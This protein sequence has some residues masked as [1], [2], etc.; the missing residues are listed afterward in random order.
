MPAGLPGDSAANNLANPSAGRPVIFDPLSG[1]KGSPFDKG[2][3]GTASTGA[4]STGI[5]FGM[6]SIFYALQRD[7][8]TLLSPQVTAA[9]AG[10]NYNQEP[11]TKP[12]YAAPPP[13]N[14]VTT[15][16]TDGRYM[17]IGGGR[18]TANATTP[19]KYSVPFVANPYV[20]GIALLAAG[21]GGSRD[22]GAGPAFTGFGMRLLA[23]TGAVANGNVVVVGYTTRSGIGLVNGQSVFTSEV[24]A[25]AAPA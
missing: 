19:D 2:S 18:S 7:G 21:N 20:T 24:A 3:V 23:A 4:L 1:P 6:N 5:G 12:T 14:V 15:N 11:G 25:Q 17:Y 16:F 9:Q 8:V 10:F 22:A 13:P